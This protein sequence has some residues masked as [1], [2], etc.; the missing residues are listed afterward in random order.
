MQLQYI[1][2]VIILIIILLAI[3]KATKKDAN[4]DFN[5]LVELLGGKDNIIE[6]ETNL[7]RFKVT[8]KDVTKA[9]KEGI[10][11][12]GAKGIVEIDNQLKIILGPESK[13][14][15]KYIDDLK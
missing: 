8:L 12:L 4:L 15:K 2:I 9:N 10:Q 13:Q 7:S 6:T 1:I 3:L 14:L 5:K 11:K